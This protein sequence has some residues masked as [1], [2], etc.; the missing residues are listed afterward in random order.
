MS[1][2][3]KMQEEHGSWFVLWLVPRA[4]IYEDALH[5]SSGF[6]DAVFLIP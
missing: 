1:M 3:V 5:V 4:E 6:W 2:T